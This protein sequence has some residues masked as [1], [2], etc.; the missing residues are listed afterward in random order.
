MTHRR[1]DAG[2][3][4]VLTDLLTIRHAQPRPP[5]HAGGRWARYATPTPR[6]GCQWHGSGLGLASMRLKINCAR[7]VLA[8]ICQR[9]D[10]EAPHATWTRVDCPVSR[11]AR[12]S[13]WEGHRLPDCLPTSPSTSSAAY[14][15][16]SFPLRTPRTAFTL[17]NAHDACGQGCQAMTM[18]GPGRVSTVTWGM[19]RLTVLQGGSTDTQE[20]R[21]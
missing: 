9:P 12:P 4:W 17:C 13:Q 16:P 1:A 18:S 7:S 11:R 3:P 8:P 15:T 6:A 20:L 2:E 5:P 21:E 19:P 14:R 10:R